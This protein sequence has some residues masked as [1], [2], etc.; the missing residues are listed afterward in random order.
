MNES[1][2]VGLVLLVRVVKLWLGEIYRLSILNVMD[3]IEISCVIRHFSVGKCIL[4]TA[5]L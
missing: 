5:A 4:I 3:L 2:E 1:S